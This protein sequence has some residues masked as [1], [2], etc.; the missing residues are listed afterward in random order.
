MDR[1]NLIRA[2]VY[3]VNGGLTGWGCATGHEA[4]AVLLMVYVIAA[5]WV[6]A[7]CGV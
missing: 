3:A 2:G 4:E 6:A 7:L 1:D 5:W